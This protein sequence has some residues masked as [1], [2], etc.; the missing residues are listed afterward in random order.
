MLQA[1]M[2][3]ALS[4]SF[5]L[6]LS[7]SHTQCLHIYVTERLF[8]HIQKHTGGLISLASLH[9]GVLGK[10]GYQ[11]QGRANTIVLPCQMFVQQLRQFVT[12]IKSYSLL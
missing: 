2:H 9:R 5:S 7:L 10:Q 11:C 12:F 1:F 8:P 6:S 3:Y 4:L